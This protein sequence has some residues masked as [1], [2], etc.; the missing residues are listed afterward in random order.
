[1]AFAVTTFT[2]DTGVKLE[3]V[4]E[5]L[6]FFEFK[7]RVSSFL[8][9]NELAEF[10]LLNLDSF[11]STEGGKFLGDQ[12]QLP[13]FQR[14]VFHTELFG[15]AGPPADL[16]DR[17]KTRPFWKYIQRI[18]PVFK[19]AG[20]DDDQ[21]QMMVVMPDTLLIRLDKQLSGVQ[22]TLLFARLRSMGLVENRA[23]TKRLVNYYLFELK[24]KSPVSLQEL[25]G[26]RGKVLQLKGIKAV[27][28]ENM[29]L[30]LN[31][32]DHTLQQ[33]QLSDIIDRQEMIFQQIRHDRNFLH[34]I[35]KRT[36]IRIA[37]LDSGGDLGHP[38]I[39][40]ASGQLQG[41]D[42]DAGY[43]SPDGQGA[44]GMA[45]MGILAGGQDQL[46][47]LDT[48]IE[49]LSLNIVQTT[50]AEVAEAIEVAAERQAR[51]ISMS[52]GVYTGSLPKW[53]VATIIDAI[54]HVHNHRDY[55]CLT[56]AATG[57]EDFKDQALFP[58]AYHL[59]MAVGAT[60]EQ[61]R[62]RVAPNPPHWRWGSNFGVFRVPGA[63]ANQ[64]YTS[65]M[66]VVAPGICIPTTD[67][68]FNH[69]G[70][71]DT[72]G[73]PYTGDPSGNYLYNFM[74]TSAAT[75]FVAA[76]AATLFSIRPDADPEQV[77]FAIEASA[78]S[79]DVHANHTTPDPH[80]GPWHP[81]VGYGSIDYTE[82]IRLFRQLAPDFQVPARISPGKTPSTQPDT[83]GN[84][85]N[86]GGGRP[87]CN[88]FARWRRR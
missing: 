63:S 23:R 42:F 29:P 80:R 13:Q 51:V 74:G 52:V 22:K 82:A 50:D 59:A 73:N 10:N 85:G 35:P 21:D 79:L 12:D 87:G 70:Y 28:Y 66:S 39:Q 61:D 4:K 46:H 5:K 75:P 19:K 43:V 84:G 65:H 47:A 62:A 9:L 33:A 55:K 72:A 68:R 34:S 83:P 45:C 11:R 64:P 18:A 8:L 48:I 67:I 27:I 86:D 1:M 53:N 49:V 57:N 2:H 24:S 15:E 54:E 41:T 6:I 78:R 58:A 81:E 30:H 37:V 20:T 14:F 69:S 40:W 36:N 38:E 17:M 77:R 26:V 16:F 32:A 31:F 25:A 71:I 88:P 3:W 76:L 7:P 44:H 56:L 60:D